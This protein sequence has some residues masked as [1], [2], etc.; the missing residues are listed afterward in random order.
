MAYYTSSAL[1]NAQA[2]LTGAFQAGELR[3]RV[4]ATFLQLLRSGSF[5]FPD[6]A[7]L[8]TRDDRTIEAKYLLRS[9][10]SLTSARA[11]NHT[12]NRGDSGTMNL[13]WTTYADPFSISIKQADNNVYSYDEM[14]SN[15]ILNSIK[16]FSVGLESAAASF[17]FANRSGVSAAAS[18]VTFNST[19]DVNQI[20]TSQKERAMQ[21]SLSAMDDNKYSGEMIVYCDAIA[22]ADFMYYAMQGAGNSNNLSF[23]FEGATFVK[24]VGLNALAVA[25]GPL[26]LY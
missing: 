4:P 6:A 13:S 20:L 14:L 17:L 21:I 24:S 22:Y 5:M 9:S 15:D 11:H 25:L 23:Q 19:D 7:T 16:N 3:E 12:G 26:L 2:R 18:Y 8:K 10:R 1:V